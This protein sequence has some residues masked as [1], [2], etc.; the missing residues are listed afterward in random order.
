VFDISPIQIAIVLVIALLVFGPKRLPD[1]AR[2]LGQSIRDF[3]RTMEEAGREDPA[4][5]PQVPAAPEP[6]H[7]A[8][9]DDDLAGVIVPGAQRPDAGT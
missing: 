6:A 4:P 8:A 3:R 5:A 1:M 2:T 7:A 9:E